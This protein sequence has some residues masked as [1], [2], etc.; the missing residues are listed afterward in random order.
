M[1]F[2]VLLILTYLSGA[3]PWS[4]WLSRLFRGADPRSQADGN[5]GAA[6]VF[7]IG[8]W[9]LGVIV[10]LLDFFQGVHSCVYW[11]MGAAIV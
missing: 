2:T 7:H 8:G 11:P 9:R 1:S 3:L 10:L 6:N 4:V 5:P